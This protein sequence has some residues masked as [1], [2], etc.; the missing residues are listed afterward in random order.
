MKAGKPEASGR[1]QALLPSNPTHF[2]TRGPK[3]LKPNQGVWQT[4]GRLLT[5]PCP[6]HRFF[7]VGM[8]ALQDGTGESDGFQQSA[9]RVIG[10]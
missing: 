7:D 10:R 2:Q 1:A 3:P 6:S 8:Q 9:F 4:K 5:V